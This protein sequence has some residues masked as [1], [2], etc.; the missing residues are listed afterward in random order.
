M[1]T[2]FCI[3]IDG[4]DEYDDKGEKPQDLVKT[5][6]ELS[7][8]DDVKLCISSRPYPIFVEEFGGTLAPNLVLK[9]ED[10]TK[11][12]I[13]Y[14]IREKFKATKNF[15]RLENITPEYSEFI[16]EVASKAEGVFLWVYLVVVNLEMGIENGDSLIKLRKR[17]DKC[18]S[19]LDEF[20]LQMLEDIDPSYQKQA[21]RT[22]DTVTSAIQPLP[23]M[24]FWYLFQIDDDPSLTEQ[25]KKGSS[26][27]P[28]KAG[29]YLDQMRRKLQAQSQGLLKIVES[30][31]D[32]FASFK[33]DFIQQLT[34]EQY[35]HNSSP[36][37]QVYSHR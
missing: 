27:S 25:W 21:M 23:I 24:L 12:D 9:V 30:R 6:W 16:S 2:R 4:L 5:I 26:S 28:L 31:P 34:Q 32:D 22:F 37:K 29:K 10:H 13:E 14:Y 17:L 33:V 11:D 20:F 15:A 8:S 18:P 36:F 3:F 35:T 1:T 7:L 19:D